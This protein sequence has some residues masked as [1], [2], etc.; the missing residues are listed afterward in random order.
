MGKPVFL[1]K[2]Y[3]PDSVTYGLIRKYFEQLNY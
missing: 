1:C 2:F 3:K